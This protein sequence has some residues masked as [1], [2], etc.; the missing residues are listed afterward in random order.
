[1]PRVVHFEIAAD[2]TGRAVKLYQKVFGWKIEK[3]GIRGAC[4]DLAHVHDA[5]KAEVLQ[6]RASPRK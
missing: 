5:C 2:D 4:R 6:S 1:M 3:W